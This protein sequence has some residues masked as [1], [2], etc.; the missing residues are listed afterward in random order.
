[1]VHTTLS[2]IINCRIQRNLGCVMGLKGYGYGEKYINYLLVDYNVSEA[3]GGV[4]EQ[5]FFQNLKAF[6]ERCAITIHSRFKTGHRKVEW[7]P[8]GHTGVQLLF[9]VSGRAKRHCQEGKPWGL[10]P[11]FRERNPGFL[12]LPLAYCANLMQSTQNRAWHVVGEG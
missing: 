7:L 9:V 11:G 10:E 1:M 4:R 6:H 12:H 3:V 2:I 5:D 8:Q